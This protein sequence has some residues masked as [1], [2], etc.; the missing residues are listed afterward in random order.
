MVTRAVEPEPEPASL[1][2]VRVRGTNG[3]SPGLGTLPPCGGSESDGLSPSGISL[4]DEPVDWSAAGDH[5]SLTVTGMD[6]I[7]IK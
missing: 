7:K 3:S 4:H 2:R 1:Q 5:V 6:I